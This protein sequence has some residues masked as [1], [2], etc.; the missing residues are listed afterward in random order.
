MIPVS[1]P[2]IGFEEL[3]AIRPVFDSGWLGMGAITYEFEEKIKILVEC[4]FKTCH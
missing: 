4:G 1:K 3:N 2:S